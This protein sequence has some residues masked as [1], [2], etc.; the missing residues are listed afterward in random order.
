MSQC[1]ESIKVENGKLFNIEE[2][3]L[4]LNKTIKDIFNKNSNIDL[5]NHIKPPK[6]NT[7]YRCKVIYDDSIKDIQFYPYTPRKIKSFKI[8]H[9]NIKYSHKYA[10]RV[11]I[12]KLFLQRDSCDDILIVGEN[13]LLKD[14]SIANIAVKK[15]DIWFTP[16]SPLLHGSMKNRLIKENILYEKDLFIQDIK[17]ID[18]FVIIN[19]MIGFHE[20]KEPK[21]KF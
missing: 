20:I 6:D 19:T 10:D 21:F 5:K 11:S 8:I 13:G 18:S 2:H 1:F 9:S 16:K 14:T 12:D 15:G 3:N 4:R 7:L 17:N